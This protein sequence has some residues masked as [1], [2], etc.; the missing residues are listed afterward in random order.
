M[1][2]ILFPKSYPALVFVILALE[3][4]VFR[5][6]S[7]FLISNVGHVIY[8][9]CLMIHRIADN[10]RRKFANTIMLWHLL[11]WAPIWT[12]MQFKDLGL[13]LFGFMAHFTI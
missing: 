5:A 3:Y 7:I 2:Y 8:K 13:L 12:M 6:K 10:L 11:L 1:L 4:A 9:S